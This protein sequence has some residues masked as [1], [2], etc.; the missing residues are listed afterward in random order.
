MA[1]P[2]YTDE[3]RAEQDARQQARIL[4]G[5]AT[6]IREKGYAATTISDIARAA[7]VSKST[8]YAH[9]ADKEECFL[10]LYAAATENLLGVMARAH[11]E[12]QEAQLP[13]RERVRAV[14]HAY[15]SAIAAGG[16]VARCCLVE[17]QAVGPRA[18]EL[19]R[20][21]L[22][23]YAGLLCRGVDTLREDH[24][25]LRPLTEDLALSVLG[26]VH[27]HMLRTIETRGA[28]KLADVTDAATE[29]MCAVLTSDKRS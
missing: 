10:A 18:L 7:S 5:L 8:V 24:P 9:Y 19:R 11:A 16:A 20:E 12:A 29:L 2:P 4:D 17:V 14:F 22:E 28:P 13:W 3:E 21:A 26:G 1:R 15:L 6:C 23:R 25:E 27:E